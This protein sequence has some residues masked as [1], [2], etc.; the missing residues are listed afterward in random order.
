VKMRSLFG[1]VNR[2][3][4][5]ECDIISYLQSLKIFW[6]SYAWDSALKMES[7]V[8]N[9][10]Q[11]RKTSF[12]KNREP[13]F[14]LITIRSEVF[15]HV[16]TSFTILQ[17]AVTCVANGFMSITYHNGR[18]WMTC[19]ILVCRETKFPGLWNMY[20]DEATQFSFYEK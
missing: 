8:C 2:K 20:L 5:F 14:Y 17:E 10:S 9:G 18:E 11:L 3:P 7:L 15:F 4:V 13:Y 16:S 1:R 6:L 19:F 12:G